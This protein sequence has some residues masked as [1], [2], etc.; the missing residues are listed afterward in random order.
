MKRV[1]HIAIDSDF[2]DSTGIRKGFEG[3]GYIVDQY[4]WQKH[5]YDLRTE[6]MNLHCIEQAKVSSP[7]I[8]FFHC[9]NPEA[10]DKMT[11][12][13]LKQVAPIIH[14]T[15]DVREDIRWYKSLARHMALSLFGCHE[16]VNSCKADGIDNVAYLPSSVDFDIYKPLMVLG[17]KL[18]EIV[19]IGNNTEGSNLNYPRARERQEMVDYMTQEFG[20]RFMAFGQGQKGG[21]V[22]REHEIE[23]YGAA[24]VVITHNNFLR[25]GYCSDR[26]FRAVGCGAFTI[27]QFF[28]GVKE[29]FGWQS[30]VWA[31]FNDIKYMC[32]YFLKASKQ[33]EREMIANREHV[34]VVQSHS[35]ADRVRKMMEYFE[36]LQLQK[37]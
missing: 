2:Y 12:L 10:F 26:D 29:M 11:V 17:Q 18:P 8:I 6:A 16:D 15:F 19:F 23:I 27:H 13:Q 28:E 7:D 3:N 20:D 21:H 9:Q 24:K 36:V 14:Y 37:Q 4:N 35:W 5:R 31:N 1:F 33:E 32:D 25:K 22:K 30:A 34:H